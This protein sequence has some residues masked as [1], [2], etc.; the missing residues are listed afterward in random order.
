M[1]TIDGTALEMGTQTGIGFGKE[2]RKEFLFDRKYR[3]LNH[4][5]VPA[6]F[7]PLLHCRLGFAERACQMLHCHPNL[8]LLGKHV[9]KRWT[10]L[11][12]LFSVCGFFNFVLFLSLSQSRKASI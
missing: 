12:L 11:L 5:E 4:G 9:K 3:N 10:V 8:R 1:T 6:P 7:L 2:L